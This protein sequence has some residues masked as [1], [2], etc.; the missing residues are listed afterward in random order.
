MTLDML[1]NKEREICALKEKDNQ[2]ALTTQGM[3]DKLEAIK[4]SLDE[5]KA[6]QKEDFSDL[7]ETMTDFIKAA[8]EKYAPILVYR[9][10]VWAGGIGGAALIIGLLT[11][12]YK[13]IISIEK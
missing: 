9:I 8:D 5:H 11:L 1:E 6:Q 3:A 12:I 13:T 10:L 2:F 7:K 4:E